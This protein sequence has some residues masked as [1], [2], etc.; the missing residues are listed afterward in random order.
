MA[1]DISLYHSTICLVASMSRKRFHP[2]ALD[3]SSSS[4]EI[5]S[6][7]I[8]RA[9]TIANTG[10]AN[11]GIA[12]VAGTGIAGTGVA[13]TGLAGTADTGVANTGI[14]DPL[15][16]MGAILTG[17]QTLDHPLS[18]MGAIFTGSQTHH[19]PTMPTGTRR[20]QHCTMPW[21]CVSPCPNAQDHVPPEPQ[22]PQRRQPVHPGTPTI[23]PRRD[24]D[25]PPMG[26][27]PEPKR[28]R[29]TTTITLTA[30]AT[31]TSSSS[32]S[33]TRSFISWQE[34]AR[35]GSF[36]SGQSTW[37]EVADKCL[38]TKVLRLDRTKTM[39]EDCLA[40]EHMSLHLPSSTYEVQHLHSVI[41]SIPETFRFKVGISW[42]PTWRYYMAHVQVAPS[43]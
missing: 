27:P 23:Q 32:S 34:V 5:A 39:V 17:S 40:D 7:A 38:T 31:T 3:D 2:W 28:R 4:D 43:P 16:S 6:T 25:D 26:A 13:S 14:A 42:C 10:I 24:V 18:S 19:T 41:A 20:C 37:Q 11:A 33:R 9:R 29:V 8:K 15:S 30:T 36:I 12:D 1:Q 35:G 21:F 22:Q